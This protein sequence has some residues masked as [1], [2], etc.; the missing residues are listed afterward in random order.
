MKPPWLHLLTA[1][2]LVLLAASAAA[3]TLFVSPS[4]DDNNPGTEQRPLATLAGA[5]DRIRQVQATGGLPNGGMTVMLRDGTYELSQPLELTKLDSGRKNAPIVYRPCDGESVKIVG[6]REVTGWKPV[7]DPIVLARLDP[8]REI[9][10]GRLTSRPS[11]SPL[12]RV[13]TVPAPTSPTR[14]WNCS[15]RT[16]P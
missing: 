6:G 2:A 12:S 16:S 8:R 5:R 3:G 11:G 7:T 4:G 14:A 13:S 1:V 9:T 10:S 15:F